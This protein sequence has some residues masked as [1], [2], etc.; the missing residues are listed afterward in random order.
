MSL[1]LQSSLADPAPHDAPLADFRGIAPIVPVRN[2]AASLRF[3]VELLGFAVLQRNE[4]S[5]AAL[6]A[7]GP[8]R[9]MLLRVGQLKALEAT[10]EHFSAYVWVSDLDA[11]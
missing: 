8:V 4:D 9:L 2:V 6:V 7:R 5:S 3:Y 10:R 11:L 1:A